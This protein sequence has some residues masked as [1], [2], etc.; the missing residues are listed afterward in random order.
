MTRPSLLDLCAREMNGGW[1]AP[2]GTRWV[3]D[4]ARYRQLRADCEVYNGRRTDPD[5]W[6]PDPGDQLFGIPVEVRED[7]GVPHL[8]HWLRAPL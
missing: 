8:E 5:T 1:G 3:M 6:M 2:A 7:G 4:L